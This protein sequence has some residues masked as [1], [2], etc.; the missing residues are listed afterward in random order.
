MREEI[1]EHR[2]AINENTN[3]IQTNFEFLCELDRKMDHLHDRIDEL[4]LIVTG[5][6]KD[7]QY[8]VSPLNHR[9][10][11]LFLTIFNMTESMPELTCAQIGK[12]VNLPPNVVASYLTKIQEK[13][14]PFIKKIRAGQVY[15]S[16]EKPFREFQIKSNIV[17]IDTPLTHW[18]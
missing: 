4:F 9:E 13:G 12:K 14:I 7:K 15:F 2:H 18:M 3:E 6:T 1:D 10:K 16:I 11:E 17:G 8:Q 5:T